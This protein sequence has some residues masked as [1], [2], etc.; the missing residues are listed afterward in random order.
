MTLKRQS[1]FVNVQATLPGFSLLEMVAVMTIVAL[2]ALVV[3]P[4]YS[5]NGGPQALKSTAF[6]IAGLL[7]QSR[8]AAIRSGQSK[9]F[10][11]SVSERRAWPAGADTSVIIP[12]EFTLRHEA[13]SRCDRHA[14]ATLIVF[15]PDGKSCGSVITLEMG[16][17]S[18]IIST[19]WLTGATRVDFTGFAESR[20][21]L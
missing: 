16:A 5:A 4:R 14:G 1:N 18:A 7:R 8:I 17:L 20:P 12:D 11:L 15:Q 10:S 2:I 9:S 6:E 13:S 21:L 3:A 19:N